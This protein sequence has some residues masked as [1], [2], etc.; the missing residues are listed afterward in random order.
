[1]PEKPPIMEK[2]WRAMSGCKDRPKP[3]PQEPQGFV[4]DIDPALVQQIL[5]VA[6]AQRVPDVLITTRK[7]TSG[8]ELKYRNGLAGLLIYPSTSLPPARK[9]L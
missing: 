5:D 2:C 9:L 3:V 6:K 1:M 8:D 4:A 7:I